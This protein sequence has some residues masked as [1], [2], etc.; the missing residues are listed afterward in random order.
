VYLETTISGH[1]VW[2]KK[3]GILVKESK[4]E[5]TSYMQIQRYLNK[6][7]NKEAHINESYID[8]MRVIQVIR[9]KT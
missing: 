5:L 6:Y 3:E 9:R 8:S 2:S 7:R 4:G 1:F